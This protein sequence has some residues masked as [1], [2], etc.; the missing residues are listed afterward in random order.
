MDLF[1]VIPLML[2]DY[3]CIDAIASPLI[4]PA[5]T[6]LEALRS[7]LILVTAGLYAQRRN[8][9]LAE[10]LFCVLRGRMRPSEAGLLQSSMTLDEGE[11]EER[12]GM[13]QAVRS[14]WPVRVV[15]KREDVGEYVLGNLVETYGGLRVED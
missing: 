12:K 14:Q 6:D 4:P 15:K 3:D 11:A 9:Y 10:A 5:S 2:L 7:T 8:H 13:A 1:I